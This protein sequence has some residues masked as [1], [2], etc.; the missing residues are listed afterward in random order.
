MSSEG[1]GVAA[2]LQ[3]EMWKLRDEVI[4]LEAELGNVRG[5]LAACRAERDSAINRA[6]DAV[7]RCAELEAQ[8]RSR[9]YRVGRTV[10][11]PLRRL[12]RVLGGR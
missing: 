4:G 8:A 10:L 12:R 6:D 3:R 11:D 9:D 7:R 5:A 2:E 1:S